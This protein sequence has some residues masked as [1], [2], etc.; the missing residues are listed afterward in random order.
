MAGLENQIRSLSLGPGGPGRQYVTASSMASVASRSSVQV[1]GG[2]L[3]HVAS[4]S[5]LNGRSTSRNDTRYESR[6]EGGGH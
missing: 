2:G 1:S 4:P 5:L 6:I 3:I